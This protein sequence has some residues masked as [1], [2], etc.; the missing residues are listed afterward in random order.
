MRNGLE[1]VKLIMGFTNAFAF[2]AVVFSS[3]V[4]IIALTACAIAITVYGSMANSGLGEI[5]LTSTK[6][7][8]ELVF[9]PNMSFH[10][11]LSHIWS[12]GQDQCFFLYQRFLKGVPTH[13]NNT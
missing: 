2:S 4:V 1:T 7:C 3:N 11:F 10:L 12:S 8:P 9:G 6:H 13:T 5:R